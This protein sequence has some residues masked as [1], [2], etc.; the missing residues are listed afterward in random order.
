MDN[1]NHSFRSIIPT[2]DPIPKRIPQPMTEEDIPADTINPEEYNRM[3]NAQRVANQMQM[4][5]QIQQQIMNDNRPL[6]ERMP[7]E[8]RLKK[9]EKLSKAIIFSLASFI[10][11][12]I[13]FELF[14]N[15]F[16][17]DLSY[18]IFNISSKITLSE[19]D[20]SYIRRLNISNIFTII[21]CNAAV[22]FIAWLVVRDRF[23]KVYLS[24]ENQK[25]YILATSIMTVG[26]IG[27]YLWNFYSQ[28][29][30]H[31]EKLADMEGFDVVSSL[32]KCYKADQIIAIILCFI[33]CIVSFFVI[34]NET[35]KRNFFVQN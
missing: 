14:F 32:T 10:I 18:K 17:N 8:H 22:I 30:K 29:S 33:T 24:I 26:L 4:Q 9:E 16:I 15:K 6:A 27:L 35:I 19:V 34:K 3:L 11:C 28:L 25:K 21:V 12:E 7:E 2:G 20:T 13:I 5:Q 1:N 23:R 31:I